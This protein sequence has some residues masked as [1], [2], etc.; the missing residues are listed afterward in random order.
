MSLQKFV[1]IVVSVCLFALLSATAP[2]SPVKATGGTVVQIMP[3]SAT[4]GTDSGLHFDDGVLAARD[5]GHTGDAYIRGMLYA[6]GLNINIRYMYFDAGDC[7]MRARL[8]K[9]VF[10]VWSDDYNYDVDILHLTGKPGSTLY[11]WTVFNPGDW[12]YSVVGQ[13][14]TCGTSVTH[15]HL[16][17]TL[18]AYVAWTY[19]GTDDT[20]WANNTECLVMPTTPRRHSPRAQTGVS[21]PGS[22]LGEY[23]TS[24]SP[25]YKRSGRVD[26][27]G[28]GHHDP[29]ECENWSGFSWGSDS[30]VFTATL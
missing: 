5:F 30:V 25:D 2:A 10:G 23:A 13:A 18:G 28:V 17:M 29:Y 7:R 8:Q 24:G 15:S 12:F 6:N 1:G 9:Y 14:S 16:G 21:C 22:W 11:T 3:S 19:A 26:Q 4:G 27:G 20:C